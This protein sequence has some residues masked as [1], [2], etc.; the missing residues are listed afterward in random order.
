MK[1]D[2]IQESE[3]KIGQYDI[4]DLFYIQKAQ[5]S[6]GLGLIFQ[7]PVELGYGPHH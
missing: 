3:M 7:S 6:L 5:K 4:E 2:L 1:A